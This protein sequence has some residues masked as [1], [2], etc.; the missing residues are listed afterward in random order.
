[1]HEPF[2]SWSKLVVLVETFRKVGNSEPTSMKIKKKTIVSSC[3]LV[4]ESCFKFVF[5]NQYPLKLKVPD[6]KNKP[7]YLAHSFKQKKSQK[8]QNDECNTFFGS[9]FE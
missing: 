1:M 3:A 9:D 4:Q 2:P 6:W 7:G 8:D 5:Q